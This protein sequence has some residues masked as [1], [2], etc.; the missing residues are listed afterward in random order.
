MV[1]INIPVPKKLKKVSSSD[2]LC[3]FANIVVSSSEFLFEIARTIDAI[4]GTKN[5]GGAAILARS[6]K[7]E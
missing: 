7:S 2:V 4:A 5:G 6:A 3:V 1:Q